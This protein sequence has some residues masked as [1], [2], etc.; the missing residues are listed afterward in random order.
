MRNKSKR[1]SA[2]CRNRLYSTITKNIN[3]DTF[4]EYSERRLLTTLQYCNL[5]LWWG[6]FRRWAERMKSQL[7]PR[8]R[9]C[10]LL[11]N[12]MEGYSSLVQKRTFWL[13]PFFSSMLES[14]CSRSRDALASVTWWQSANWFCG[15][16]RH[17]RLCSLHVCYLARSSSS[18]RI[19]FRFHVHGAPWTN[20]S[21]LYPGSRPDYP[22]VR[23]KTQ[24]HSRSPKLLRDGLHR[25]HVDYRVERGRGLGDA[26][27]RALQEPVD[28]PGLLLAALR[29]TGTPGWLQ[30][31]GFLNHVTLKQERCSLLL[32]RSGNVGGAYRNCLHQ[33]YQIWFFL[34]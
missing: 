26:A 10:P 24:N 15:K 25:S 11:W 33:T 13:G 21:P 29:H 7:N 9:C 23:R 20:L 32:S 12:R 30:P 22:A 16:H 8:R 5:G 2:V 31:V 6:D 4:S 17:E 19:L 34:I 28:A 1:V 27:R 18:K 14:F 3:L